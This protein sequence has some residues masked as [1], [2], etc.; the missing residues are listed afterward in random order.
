VDNCWSGAMND[1][2]ETMDGWER[3]DDRDDII[4]RANNLVR[5]CGVCEDDILIFPPAADDLTITYG[6]IEG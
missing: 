5:E 3:W 6:E 1:E 2:G 4:N